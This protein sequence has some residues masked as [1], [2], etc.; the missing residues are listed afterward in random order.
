MKKFN[1]SRNIIIALT[2]VILMVL[3]ISFSAMQRDNK[4]QSLP[5]QSEVNGI[6]ATID[7]VIKA[8]IVG[9]ENM[10]K[11]INNLFNTYSENDNLK[12]KVDKVEA[13]KNDIT[14]L[15]D[16]N[17]KLKQQLELNENLLNYDVINASVINRSP[18]SWQDT[19]IIDKGTADGIEVNMA[20]M[21]DK[22]LI[23]R[24]IIAEKHSSKVELLT[25]VN[26]T[27]NHFPVM[28]ENKKGE[29]AY[30]LMEA[31]NNKTHTLVVSQLTSAEDIEV[32]TTVSTSGL[33]NNSPKGLIIGE[34]K[35]VKKS[36][37]GL[38]DEVSITPLA[39]MYDVSVVTVVK[40]L[41]GSN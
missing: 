6:I 3:L 23:G 29:M 33:G 37:T 19:L 2:I 17:E 20:V 16:E 11:S 34:V 8:P 14:N 31:Y 32:G 35:E 36:K 12:K 30:G 15:K 18:D 38:T 40:R 22:G 28:L 39:N 21:G 7:N 5:G 10:A 26:Q 4:K 9:V 1:S 25:T 24:V 13:L 41:A 27:T